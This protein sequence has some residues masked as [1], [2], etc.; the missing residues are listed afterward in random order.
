MFNLKEENL[1]L[2]EDH[3]GREIKYPCY[4]R[5]MYVPDGLPPLNCH[6]C[7]AVAIVVEMLQQI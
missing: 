6:I 2:I 5:G 7:Y 4:E 1:F 3:Q